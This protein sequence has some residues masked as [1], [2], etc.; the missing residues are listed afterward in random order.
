M[1][2]MMKLVDDSCSEAVDARMA[3]FDA[4]CAHV[5]REQENN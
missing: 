5:K 1:V 3:C 4:L 2:S